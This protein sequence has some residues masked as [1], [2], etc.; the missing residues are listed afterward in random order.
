[1]KSNEKKSRERIT[2]FAS[3]YIDEILKAQEVTV[4]SPIHNHVRC[5]LPKTNYVKV[6]FYGAFKGAD[7]GSGTWAVIKRC[8]GI[9]ARSK[10]K[11]LYWF[12]GSSGDSGY[13]CFRCNLLCS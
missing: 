4:S 1:M 5:E 6:N 13:S 7:N 2:R 3:D 12:S 9:C 10:F 8:R 11:V